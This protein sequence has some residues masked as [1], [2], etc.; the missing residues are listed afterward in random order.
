MD[1]DFLLENRS[2]QGPRWDIL[3]LQIDPECVSDLGP[4]TGS[5]WGTHSEGVE[6]RFC[7]YLQHFSEVWH[8]S[9][10]SILDSILTTMLER[11]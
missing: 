6:V 5:V 3:A 10:D 11:K 7:C 1:P 2:F 9:K 8:L 4:Q